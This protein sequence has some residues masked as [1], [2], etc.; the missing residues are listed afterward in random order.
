MLNTFVYLKKLISI[1]LLL[2]LM[3]SNTEF[4]QLMKLPV[5][6]KHYMDHRNSDQSLSF[7]DFILAHYGDQLDTQDKTHEELP[8]KSHEC[9]HMSPLVLVCEF[10][11]YKAP[12]LHAE[13][14]ALAGYQEDFYTSGSF[15]SIWQPPQ[16]LA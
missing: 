1:G 9:Q 2:L 15:G 3:G 8:F 14:K 13:P 16:L 10:H 12:I 5:L 11:A 7:A 4:H 6:I